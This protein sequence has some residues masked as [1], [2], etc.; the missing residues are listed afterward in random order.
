MRPVSPG[1]I[2]PQPE[3]GVSRREIASRFIPVF[4]GLAG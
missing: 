3:I 1:G 4:G 2:P